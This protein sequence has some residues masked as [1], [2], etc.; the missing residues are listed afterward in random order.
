[1]MSSKWQSILVGCLGGAGLLSVAFAA[2]QAGVVTNAEFSQEIV[3]QLAVAADKKIVLPAPNNSLAQNRRNNGFRN[4][5]S[6]NALAMNTTAPVAAE[7]A[8]ANN[9]V[10]RGVALRGSI[11]PGQADWTSSAAN[12]AAVNADKPIAQILTNQLATLQAQSDVLDQRVQLLS[13]VMMEMTQQMQKVNLEMTEQRSLLE[14]I[15]MLKPKSPWQQLFDSSGFVAISGVLLLVLGSLLGAGWA[16]NR[17]VHF[18]GSQPVAFAPA[19][20]APAMTEVKMPT[21]SVM[22]DSAVEYN[23]LGTAEAIPAKLDL[24]RA[25]VA[26]EDN[27]A[28]RKVL[29]EVL[30]DGNEIHRQEARKI[31]NSF[32]APA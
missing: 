32:S 19:P 5:L 14:P 17:R 22:E 30:K 4:H 28:A 12:I 7:A 11:D 1:M 23:F 29:D 16:R 31:L 26:M 25:Y 10:T 21:S 9:A 6:N 18:T 2:N 13:Q 8:T 27:M 20:V 24:A 3:H 15:Q